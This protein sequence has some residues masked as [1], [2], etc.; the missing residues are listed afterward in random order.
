M[1][2]SLS[3]VLIHAVFSTKNRQ[4]FLADSAFRQQ[5][6]AY[7]GGVSKRLDCPPIAIGGV[8]DHVHALVRLTLTMTIADWMKEIKRVSSSFAKARVPEFGW[9]AGYGVFS[10][11][12]SSLV[13]VSAYVRGQ[14][15]HHRKI[16]FQDEL[17]QLMREHGVEWDERYVW[18]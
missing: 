12:P 13:R 4:P 18:D 5:V 2:Q 9:Q 10:V 11:D 3:C 15:E 17:R 16:S 1:P 14:E 7:I 6:H 8:E